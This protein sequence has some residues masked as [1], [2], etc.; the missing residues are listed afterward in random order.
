MV[1]FRL[2]LMSRT[3]LLYKSMRSEKWQYRFCVRICRSATKCLHLVLPLLRSK[4]FPHM[5]V[6]SQMRYSPILFY[7]RTNT[8]RW[9]HRD[10]YWILMRG[11]QSARRSEKSFYKSPMIKSYA[12]RHGE[13]NYKNDR[14]EKISRQNSLNWAVGRIRCT[15]KWA[16][17]E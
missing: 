11:P 3:V 2:Y 1:F 4:L 16:N 8:C 14:F 5:P 7:S 12:C 13:I 15:R 17:D 6:C 10:P 9:P